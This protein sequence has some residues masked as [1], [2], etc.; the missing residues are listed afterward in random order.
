MLNQGM[1]ERGETRTMAPN[2]ISS[3]SKLYAV[4]KT[5]GKLRVYF[6]GASGGQ[7]TDFTPRTTLSPDKIA[8]TAVTSDFYPELNW[9][10][11]YRTV[12]IKGTEKV[13]EEDAFLIEKTPEKGQIVTEYVSAKSYL[14]IRRDTTILSPLAGPLP[15]SEVF[16]DFRTVG[17][18]VIPFTHTSKQAGIGEMVTQIITMKQDEKFPASMFQAKGGAK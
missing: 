14:V 3:E 11:L 2:S 13:G 15:A 18:V 4:G 16:S 9:K 12:V 17:G 10:K 5:I 7:E 6:D 8:E 1:E